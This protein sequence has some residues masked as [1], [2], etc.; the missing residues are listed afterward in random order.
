MTASHTLPVQ[1]AIQQIPKHGVLV[2]WGFGIKVRLDQNHFLA[3]WGVGLNRYCV[4]LSRVEGHKLRR[5]ILLGSDGYISLESLRFITDVGASFS[6][7]D[8]RGKPLMVCSPVAPSDSK[9]RRAQSLAITNGT[10][11][12]LS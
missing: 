2:L 6:I 8:R 4:R 12:R 1:P 3:E 10:A 7:I 5:V 11:L 9:P